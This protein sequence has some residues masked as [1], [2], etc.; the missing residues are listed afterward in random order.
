MDNFYK[1]NSEKFPIAVDFSTNIESGDSIASKDVSAIIIA[2]SADATATVIDSSLLVSTSNIIKAVVKDGTTGTNYKI[3]F[4]ATTTN[5]YIY[6]HDVAML[7][8]N[9]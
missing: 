6:E 2:S 8:R 5:G 9:V 4:K 7:V 1:Q 3:T